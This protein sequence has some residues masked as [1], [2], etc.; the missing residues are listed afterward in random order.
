MKVKVDKDEYEQLLKRV[1]ELE[2]DRDL[3]WKRFN[4]LTENMQNYLENFFTK[5]CITVMIKRDKDLVEAE[6]R[7]KVMDNLFKEEQ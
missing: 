5:K 6:I 3:D 4:A 7:K 1:K 2:E